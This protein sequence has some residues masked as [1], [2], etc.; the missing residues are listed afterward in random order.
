MLAVS[1]TALVLVAAGK[2]TR[3]GSAV[4][5]KVL[6]PLAGRP[7][8]A[9][10]LDAFAASGVVSCVV[11]VLR[12]WEQKRA[13][14]PWIPKNLEVFWASG[15]GRRQDSVLQ[16]LLALPTHIEYVLVH[17]AARPLIRPAAIRSLVEGLGSYAAATLVG[18]VVD[19]I[20]QAD[21]EGL[22]LGKALQRSKLRAVQTPQAAGRQGLHEALERFTDEDFTDESSLMHHAGHA[23]ALIHNPDP[24][25]KLT[26]ENDFFILL[27]FLK[28]T[29]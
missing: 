28:K 10:S 13:I 22:F 14:E 7:V 18:P 11:V 3:M 4:E 24:N 16:G 29:D 2:G 21:V 25:P 17:D 9:Y 23:V 20:V 6:L 8:I 26:C 1:K 12:D 27:S 19:T 5:D 15:G